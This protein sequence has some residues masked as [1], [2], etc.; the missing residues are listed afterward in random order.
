MP[1]SLPQWWNWLKKSRFIFLTKINCCFY[2][3]L[4][5]CCR[6]WLSCST[7]CWV[8]VLLHVL[9]TSVY[10]LMMPVTSLHTLL[11][12]LHLHQGLF[13]IIPHTERLRTKSQIKKRS[14]SRL[15]FLQSLS[16]NFCSQSPRSCSSA[17]VSPYGRSPSPL[18]QAWI[19]QVIIVPSPHQESIVLLLRL[20]NSTNYYSSAG[21]T[22]S[23]RSE[24]WALFS[25]WCL[26][27]ANLAL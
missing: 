14:F 9:L 12:Q 19:V 1:V 5:H 18:P 26:L 24:H 17:F 21:P 25:C 10:L 20:S 4:F 23:F 7:H 11:I 3:P 15:E 13:S 27:P 16:S 22:K 8:S 6:I 2:L